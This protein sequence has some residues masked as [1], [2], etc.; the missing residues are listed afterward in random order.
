M[1]SECYTSIKSNDGFGA[2]Y[3]R[4]IQ[5]YIYC[6]LHK[7]N[8]LYRPFEFIEHNYNNDGDFIKK[9]ETFINLKNNI[10][11]I[12]NDINSI[13]YGSVVMKYCE[14]N[15][16]KVCN[17]EHLEFIK[18]C[19]WEHKD[20]NVFNN[21]KVNVAVHIRR[22]NKIDKGIA[23]A[24]VT[25]PNSYYLNIMNIIREKYKNNNLQFHIYSQ[26]NIENFK[27]FQEKDV[28]FHLDEDVCQTFLGLVAAN[29]LVTSPSS[30][31]YCAA[32]LSDGE[33]YYKK[34]WHN[35]RKEW[36]NCE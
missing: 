18:K 7:L 19:F 27:I 23:G 32:L 25:T 17:T 35:P 9:M 21:N 16:D 33:I 31:S 3:Q 8:F 30:F 1:L 12:N 14:S 5:T 11:N 36:I 20:R 2:Q 34:F 28:E 13:D 29:I 6:K 24:R 15:I 4:I 10:L 22:E 26:G